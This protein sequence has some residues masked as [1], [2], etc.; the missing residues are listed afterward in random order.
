MSIPRATYEDNQIVEDLGEL[1]VGVC[2]APHW[3]EPQLDAVV[4]GE[5]PQRWRLSTK[6]AGDPFPLHVHVVSR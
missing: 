6:S 5:R 3:G 4:A 2:R 1:P